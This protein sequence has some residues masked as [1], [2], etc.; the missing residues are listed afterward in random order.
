MTA[1]EARKICEDEDGTAHLPVVV[2][3][4]VWQGAYEEGHAYGMGCVMATYPEHAERALLIFNAGV[5]SERQRIL[6]RIRDMGPD[7]DSGDFAGELEAP[8]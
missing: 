2:R 5:T 4:A 8:R 3:D 7:F 1:D 6:A